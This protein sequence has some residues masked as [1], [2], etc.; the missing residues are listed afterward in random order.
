[1][2]L[3]PGEASCRS[4][5]VAAFQLLYCLYNLCAFPPG[6]RLFSTPLLLQSPKLNQAVLLDA[7]T[8][9]CLVLSSSPARWDS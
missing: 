9:T 8:V 3:L 1:M 7:E 2:D 5:L 6:D 4:R